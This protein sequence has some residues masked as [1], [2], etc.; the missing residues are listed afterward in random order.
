MSLELQLMDSM[1]EDLCKLRRLLWEREAN[2]QRETSQADKPSD[3]PS[4]K[5]LTIEWYDDQGTQLLRKQVELPAQNQIDNI[6]I[7]TVVKYEADC[8]SVNQQATMIKIYFR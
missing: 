5:P 1:H 3:K 2:T 8:F 6:D 7:D 4:D